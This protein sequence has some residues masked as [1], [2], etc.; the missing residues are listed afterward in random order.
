MGSYPRDFLHHH[1]HKRL[2]NFLCCI[3][4]LKGRAPNKCMMYVQHVVLCCVM[5]YYMLCRIM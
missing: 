3:S 4:L 1:Y 2:G 5:L